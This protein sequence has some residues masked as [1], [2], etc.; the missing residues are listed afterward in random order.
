MVS[1]EVRAANEGDKRNPP[2]EIVAFRI[3]RTLYN[4]HS[5]AKAK[6]EKEETGHQRNERRMA[7]WT[8]RVGWFSGFL[9][10]FSA[11]G[12]WIIYSQL[13]EMRF[14]GEDTKQLIKAAQDSAKAA[15]DAVKLAEDTAKRQLRAYVFADAFEMAFSDK[16]AVLTATF[17]NTGQTPAFNATAN[18]LL[19]VEKDGVILR[20]SPIISRK[21]YGS[22]GRDPPL[23]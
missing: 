18:G 12:N 6:K 15:Q 2:R 7:Q 20:Q 17:K 10:F 22:Y 3:F 5:R 19:S 9:V 4:R 16:K 23:S 21:D 14:S 1:E 13:R 8:A 11:V